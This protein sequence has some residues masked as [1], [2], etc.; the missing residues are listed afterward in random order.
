MMKS[1]KN[2]NINKLRLQTNLE[3]IHYG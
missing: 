2:I 3:E 1:D